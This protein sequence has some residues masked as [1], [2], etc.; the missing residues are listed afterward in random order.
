MV[1]VPVGTMVP[2]PVVA[3]VSV[4]VGTIVSVPV[5]TVVPVPTEY[6]AGWSPSPSQDLVQDSL[7]TLLSRSPTLSV[8]HLP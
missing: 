2:V 5:G 1:S 4:P 3:V 7:V 6:A 8:A